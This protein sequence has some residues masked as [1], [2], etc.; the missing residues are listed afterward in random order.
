MQDNACEKI[1]D[2]ICSTNYKNL[3][4]INIGYYSMEKILKILLEAHNQ[5]YIP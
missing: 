5:I 3:K 4:K 2:V 1:N